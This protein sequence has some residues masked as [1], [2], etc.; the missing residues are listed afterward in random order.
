[1]EI[2]KSPSGK[3]LVDFGQNLVGKL[4]VR[5]PL[6]SARQHP[7]AHIL[8]FS[9]AEVLEGGELGTRPLRGAK[10]VD[11]VILSPKQP[12]SWSPKFTFHGFRYVQIDGWPSDDSMPGYDD[13]T[14]LVLHSDMKRTGWFSCSDPP[15]YE[16][17]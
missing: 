10:P 17:A 12:S 1:M 8:S 7:E 3:T 6:P 5:L 9:H 13:I 14:A 4:S 11:K 2:F 16:T 15:H